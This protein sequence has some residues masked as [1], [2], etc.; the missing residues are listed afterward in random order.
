MQMLDMNELHKAFKNLKKDELILDVRY[1]DEFIEGHV[2][3]SKNISHDE[4]SNH[5]PELK[6]YSK[7]YI[8]CAAGGRAQKATIAL[9]SAGIE[10]IVTIVGGGM[11]DWIDS[12]YPVEK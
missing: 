9:M 11:Q 6:K 1:P 10:N 4:V 3:G 5:V 7:I 2:P 12:S 8:Y